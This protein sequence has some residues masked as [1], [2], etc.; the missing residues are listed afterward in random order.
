MSTPPENERL[1]GKR[2]KQKLRS[3]FASK[4]RNSGVPDARP[5]GT[6]VPSTATNPV[7]VVSSAHS[8]SRVPPVQETIIVNPNLTM[9]GPTDIGELISH[10]SCF[11]PALKPL[12]DHGSDLGA[13]VLTGPPPLDS[14]QGNPGLE[15]PT[16]GGTC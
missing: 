4:S 13:V 10:P 5:T 8:N 3:V 15:T 7:V 11:D 6:N 2:F 1:L 14:I 9:E 12:P 16:Q